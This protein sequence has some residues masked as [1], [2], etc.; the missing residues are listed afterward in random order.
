LKQGALPGCVLVDGS[1]QSIRVPLPMLKVTLALISV[2]ARSRSLRALLRFVMRVLNA[3]V[4]VPLVATTVHAREP[5][6]GARSHYRLI[7]VI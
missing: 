6:A 1:A 7:R 4:L 5:Q 2:S 3:A